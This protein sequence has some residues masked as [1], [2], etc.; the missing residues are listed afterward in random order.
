M[1]ND[2]KVTDYEGYRQVNKLLESIDYFPLDYLRKAESFKLKEQLN[3]D[4]HMMVRARIK[5]DF[6]EFCRYASLQVELLLDEFIIKMKNSG[7]VEITETSYDNKKIIKIK[8][9]GNNQEILV[10]TIQQ[11]IDYVLMTMNKVNKCKN[12]SLM[13]Q[14]RNFASH[15]D[16]ARLHH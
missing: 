6:R 13:F 11:R 4:C 16:T 15:R 9:L 14:I 7:R 1:T 5:D 12:V 8:N 3:D 10:E 2:I